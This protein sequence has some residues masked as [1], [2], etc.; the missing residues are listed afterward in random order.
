MTGWLDEWMD[1]W[2][3]ELKKKRREESFIGWNGWMDEWMDGWMDGWM[4]E[5][6]NGWMDGWMDEWMDVLSPSFLLCKL[7]MHIAK[8]ITKRHKKNLYYSMKFKFVKFW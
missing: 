7:V 1:G 5:W 2:I 8:C 3:D 6:M 4:D